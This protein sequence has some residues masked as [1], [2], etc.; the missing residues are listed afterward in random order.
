MNKYVNKYNEKN[1]LEEITEKVA[2]LSK[3][4]KKVE[5]R[6]LQEKKILR[7]C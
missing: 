4:P 2:T 6:A 7:R 1:I 5:V 3:A